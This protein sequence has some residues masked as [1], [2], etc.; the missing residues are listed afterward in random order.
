MFYSLSNLTP[1]NL[2]SYEISN[3]SH[4]A[5]LEIQYIRRSIVENIDA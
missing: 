1:Y 3:F 4:I 5:T 2:G